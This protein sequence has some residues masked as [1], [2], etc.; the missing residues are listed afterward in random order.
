MNL[1][2]S[3]RSTKLVC[4]C[5]M[6]LS[7]LVRADETIVLDAQVNVLELSPTNSARVTGANGN[8]TMY[9][10]GNAHYGSPSSAIWRSVAWMISPPGT[11][12]EFVRVPI[13]SSVSALVSDPGNA[14]LLDA[15][16]SLGDNWGQADLELRDSGNQAVWNASLDAGLNV[17]EFN[18]TTA[19]QFATTTSTLGTYKVTLTGSA[20]HGSPGSPYRGAMLFYHDPTD[21]TLDFEPIAV[22][23]SAVVHGDNVQIFIADGEGTLGDNAGSLTATLSIVP[24]PGAFVALAFGLGMLSRRV[25][26][27]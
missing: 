16:G 13:G 5:L 20:H 11:G 1:L 24:E 6:G 10:S 12:L 3:S 15:P 22:G 25:R 14:M 18:N 26:A 21:G 23:G 27:Q 19:P 4:L 8:V 7:P 17:I 2:L 9:A